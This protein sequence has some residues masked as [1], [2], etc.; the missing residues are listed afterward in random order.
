MSGLGYLSW[1]LALVILE[2][3]NKALTGRNIFL[4]PL[5]ASF[6]M[7]AWDLSMDPVWADIDHAWVWRDGGPYYGVPV[8]NF[9]GWSLTAYI[10][11]QIFALYL[12]NRE[13]MPLRTSHWRLAILFYAASAAGNLLVIAPCL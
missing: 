10:F 9:F 1:V 12:Q 3:Q 2:C 6:V 7:T 8:S 5:A 11:Y 13:L 4:L